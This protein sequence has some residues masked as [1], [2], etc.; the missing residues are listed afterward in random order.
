[1]TQV[2]N[3]YFRK[4][5]QYLIIMHLYIKLLK[6]CSPFLIILLIPAFLLSCKNEPKSKEVSYNSE[7]KS[8]Q[9]K[10]GNE[11]ADLINIRTEN[12]DIIMPDTLQSGWNTFKYSN[13]SDMVHLILADKLPIVDGEQI[14]AEDLETEVG[15]V[16]QKG[17]DLIIQGKQEE[18]FA[19][20]GK[21]PK[22]IGEIKYTGGIGLLSAGETSRV[23]F[24]LE[25]GLYRFECYVKTGGQFHTS[26]GM[27]K[28]VVVTDQ[29]SS[30]TPPSSDITVNLSSDNGIEIIGEIESGPQI[31]EVNFKDQKVHEHMLGHDLNLVKIDEN[32]EIQELEKWMNWIE[33]KGLETS[34][35]PAVFLGG[36]QDM[37]E[38]NKAYVNFNLKPGKYAFI[39]E[40]PEA[41]KKNM[42]KVFTVP[43]D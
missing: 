5:N 29:E 34:T 15:P 3:L 43:A 9:D 25:P 33:P 27:Y 17:M 16:F 21:F 31:V 39:A 18:G 7:L 37:P 35:E 2:R 32:T 26:M 19:E 40:V 41:S 14:G 30:T 4:T 23:T 20:F 6:R 13:D 42:L 36:I 38:G 1:M 24:K 28:E 11:V 22:W 12:M 8:S 10:S